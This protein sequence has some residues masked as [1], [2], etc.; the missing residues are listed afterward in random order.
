MPSSW[1]VPGN[2]VFHATVI[3]DWTNHYYYHRTIHGDDDY[4]C[5][6][7]CGQVMPCFDR[8]LEASRLDFVHKPARNKADQL[9]ADVQQQ[10]NDNDDFSEVREICS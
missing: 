8:K 3:N 7:N 5:G 9:A 2:R 4:Y 10:Y 6:V 1:G